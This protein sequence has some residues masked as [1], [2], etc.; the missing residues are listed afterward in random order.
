MEPLLLLSERNRRAELRL[1]CVIVAIFSGI[2]YAL[3]WKWDYLGCSLGNVALVVGVP[4]ILGF[5][6]ISNN[7]GELTVICV[8]MVSLMAVAL[9]A[10]KIAQTKSAE[11]TELA[12]GRSVVKALLQYASEHGGIF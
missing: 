11:T 8:I 10:W 4:L 9:P 2:C 5:F 6:A 3:L 12:N 1:R 7:E